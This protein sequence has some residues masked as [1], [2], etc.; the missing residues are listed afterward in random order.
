MGV[1]IPEDRRAPSGHV[2]KCGACGKKSADLYGI[3]GHHS[4]GWDESCVLNAVAVPLTPPENS[5]IANK[6]QDNGTQV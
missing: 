2:W 6:E 4:Y 1:E 3:V 5:E